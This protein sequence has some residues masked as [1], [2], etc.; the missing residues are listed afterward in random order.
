MRGVGLVMDE[1]LRTLT[2]EDVNRI[3]DGLWKKATD[4]FKLNIGDG[5]IGLAWKAM[6]LAIL[7]LAVYGAGF[8][9][10]ME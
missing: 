7:A 8:R 6:L 1:S 10:K 5:I 4:T 9:M 3:V 2:D